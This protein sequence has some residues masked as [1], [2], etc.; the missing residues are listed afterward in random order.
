MDRQ[1]AG[2]QA[3][4]PGGTLVD[5]DRRLL[6][7]E[8]HV[9]A[10]LGRGAMGQGRG[11]VAAWQHA[12]GAVLFGALDQRQP[13]HAHVAGRHVPVVGVLVPSDGLRPARLLDEQAGAPAQQVRAEDGL[14]LVEDAGVTHDIGQRGHLEVRLVAQDV[15]LAH[16][17]P[18]PEFL[19]RRT[20]S[21]RLCR[22]EAGQRGQIPVAAVRRN[23]LG[24][25]TSCHLSAPFAGRCRIAGSR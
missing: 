5:L 2:R 14:D 22:L 6:I 10:A 23:L 9:G 19:D 17:V 12:H 11:R 18:P 3:A 13:H 1:L 15:R 4:S 7:G 25:Q 16:P 24:G 20:P 8:Q 21:G